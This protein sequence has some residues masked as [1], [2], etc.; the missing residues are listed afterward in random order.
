MTVLVATSLASINSCNLD[1]L[2]GPDTPSTTTTTTTI[3][4]RQARKPVFNPG[5]SIF[6][7][8]MSLTLAAAGTN[9]VI[10]YTL[11]GSE[12]DEESTTYAGPVILDQSVLVRARAW[13]QGYLASDVAE[14]WYVQA[15]P[16]SLE[17]EITAPYEYG[18]VIVQSGPNTD[19]PFILGSPASIGID[20]PTVFRDGDAYAM[21][22]IGF[23]GTGYSTGL[24]RSPDLRTWTFSSW[25]GSY[26]ERADA[27]AGS[28][29]KYNFAGYLACEHTWGSVPVP[30]MADM[31]GDGE[32]DYL[33]SFLTSDTPGY[34]S[35]NTAAGLA[36][37]KQLEGPWQRLPEPILQA[38][39]PHEFGNQGYGRIWKAQLVKDGE[40]WRLY[41]NAGQPEKIY[42]AV[43]TDLQT[44]IRI[45]PYPMVGTGGGWGTW[46]IGDPQVV[47]IPQG[48]TALQV[49]FFF[50]DST[51]WAHGMGIVDTWAVSADGEHW[52]RSQR[53]LNPTL[54]PERPYNHHLAHKPWVFKEAGTVYRYYCAVQAFPAANGKAAY[55]IKSVALAT[56]DAG[57]LGASELK[58]W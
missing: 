57:D 11:D 52:V 26:D 32:P 20:S 56:S 29:D 31:D 3:A 58:W 12:P 13:V 43:S 22:F 49:M 37:A 35:G 27:P 39:L 48:E 14:S 15:N 53:A 19:D 47:A 17:A 51:L 55:E 33:M 28:W 42:G 16:D 41:F 5:P 6:T 30:L 7:D 54:D 25:I 38:E 21:T 9:P 4:P 36:W 34:E 44:W 10:R 24:A 40:I 8:N 46:I 18:P 2:F 50:N 23:D 45:G 1:Q